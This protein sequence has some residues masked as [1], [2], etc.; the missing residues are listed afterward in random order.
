MERCKA[1][2][3][4]LWLRQNPSA[5]WDDVASA[6]EQL[7]EKVLASELRALCRI[8]SPVLPAYLATPVPVDEQTQEQET[9]PGLQAIY[10]A[11]LFTMSLL[12]SNL[13]VRLIVNKWARFSV[14]GSL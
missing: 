9:V 4:D 5:R 7:N 13:Q 2:L 1:E 6:L 11:H 8:S 14:G 12:P 10:R 3:F